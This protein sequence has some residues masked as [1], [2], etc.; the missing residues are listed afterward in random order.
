MAYDESEDHKKAY[1]WTEY[2]DHGDL[3][4]FIETKVSKICRSEKDSESNAGMVYYGRNR[5]SVGVS[6]PWPFKGE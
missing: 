6:P 1:L 2:C 4:Q 3:S 5:G